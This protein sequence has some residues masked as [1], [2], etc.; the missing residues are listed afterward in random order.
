MQ[1]YI[2]EKHLLNSFLASIQKKFELIAPV[3]TDVSRFTRIE[4]QKDIEKIYLEKNS[5]FPAKEFFFRK[6]ETVFEFDGNNISVPRQQK[7]KRAFFGLRKCDLNA[8][9]HQ[10]MVYMSDV[11]D[12]YY[13]GAR[14]GS[15]LLGYH[16]NVAP[17]IYC[18]CSSMKL[19]DFFDLMFYNRGA[20]FLVEVG[21]KK[22]ESIISENKKFFKPTIM[23]IT[24]EEKKILKT[25]RLE[26]KDISGL[27]D[28]P[29]WKEGVDD[30]LSCTACTALCPTCYCFE[31][32]DEVSSK[33]PKKGKRVREWSSCQ[34]KGFSEVAG[35]H[36][37][38]KERDQRFKHR[39]YHQLEYFKEKHK[40]PL[41]VGCGR[42]IEGCPTR[43]D[44]V[45]II[46]RM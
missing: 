20:Q 3:K 34:L 42:C 10:D 1:V 12:P 29:K 44:F 18:F 45:D 16:C 17:S 37:F 22:G 13:T 19:E 41:C 7:T 8:I 30:C 26:K 15:V 40:I 33:D 5:Y 39:I 11:K 35:G 43:I 9:K 32:H 27:Y 14:E 46:N 6:H 25:D 36:V 2:L 23:V 21:S 4:T 24:P 28:N 38:R 31:L